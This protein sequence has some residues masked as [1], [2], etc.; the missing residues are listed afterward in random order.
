LTAAIARIMGFDS[1]SVS[2]AQHVKDTRAANR[3]L[4]D[5]LAKAHRWQT[6]REAGGYASLEDL[7]HA[8][9]CDRTYVSRMPLRLTSLSP[10]IIEAILRG[11]EPDGLSLEK[12]RKNLPVSWQQQT[13][14][15][16]ARQ[17]YWR[18]RGRV[19]G[20]WSA[21]HLDSSKCTPSQPPRIRWPTSPLI[22]SSWPE[23]QGLVSHGEPTVPAPM[24]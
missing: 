20:A 11:D 13:E 14:M 2:A 4:I 19:S 16:A 6:Q 15:W 24:A 21:D 18:P 23:T 17:G 12:L 9:G 5:A 7:A 3:T 8:V 10:D 22:R 1:R